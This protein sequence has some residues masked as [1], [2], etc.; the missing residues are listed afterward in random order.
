MSD[1]RRV[2]FEVKVPRGVGG[3]Q[4][5]TVEV[6]VEEA[7]ALI[8]HLRREIRAADV[9]ATEADNFRRKQRRANRKKNGAPS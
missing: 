6:R 2:T 4:A 9:E 5:V 1:A 3:L 7:R 8:L